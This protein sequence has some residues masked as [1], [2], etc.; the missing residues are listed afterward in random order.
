MSGRIL[1]FS[2]GHNFCSV[3]KYIG[4][5]WNQNYDYR[6]HKFPTSLEIRL[7]LLVCTENYDLVQAGNIFIRSLVLFSCN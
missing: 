5:Q 7:E 6:V 3:S 4:F 2:F 1:D